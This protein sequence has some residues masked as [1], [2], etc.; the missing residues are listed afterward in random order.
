EFA[1]LFCTNGFGVGI[2]YGNV[3]VVV[4]YDGISNLLDF[5]QESGR[6]GRKRTH[7]LRR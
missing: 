6:A 7:Q 1:L 3:T 4:H 5:V 2:D